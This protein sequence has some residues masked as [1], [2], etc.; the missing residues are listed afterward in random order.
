[1]A[2][3]SK[4]M[5]DAFNE[6]IKNEIYSGYM[7]LSMS[8][9]F[10]TQS[11]P[12]FAHWMKVQYVEELNHANKMFD[13]VTDRNGAVTLQMI[14]QPPTE[15]TSALAIFQATLEH[16]QKVTALI[17]H[18]C[19]LADQENDYTSQQFLTWFTNEQIEEEKNATLMRDRLKAIGAMA[20]ML[21]MLDGHFDDRKASLSV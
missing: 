20:G 4:T 15:F 19:S 9:W 16:E 12:G 13:Y 1:M 17:Q 7:Y 18:L 11:L 3:I 21:V 6:Q 14:P 2:D 8:A 5:Q 10:E